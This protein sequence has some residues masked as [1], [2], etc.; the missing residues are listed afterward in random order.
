MWN[1]LEGQDWIDNN[2]NESYFSLE[3]KQSYYYIYFL[4]TQTKAKS[5]VED[6]WY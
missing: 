2:D 6:D 5:G 1:D 3:K 4:S